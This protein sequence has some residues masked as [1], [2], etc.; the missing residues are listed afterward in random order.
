MGGQLRFVDVDDRRS[1]VVEDVEGRSVDFGRPPPPPRFWPT[2]GGGALVMR[3]G[4][5]MPSKMN[6]R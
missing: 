2:P 6:P 3:W 5:R 1:V 4:G